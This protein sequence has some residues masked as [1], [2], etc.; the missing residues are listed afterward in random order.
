MNKAETSQEFGE[1]RN[2]IENYDND[3]L[4]Q[5]ENLRKIDM[6][7]VITPFQEVNPNA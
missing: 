2:L 6:S 3:S 1:L 7:Y 5:V 4:C